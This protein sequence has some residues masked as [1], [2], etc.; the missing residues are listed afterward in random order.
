M[1]TDFSESP[2][3]ALL[4]AARLFTGREPI[5]YHAHALPMG[6]S[7]DA[8]AHSAVPVSLA[9]TEAECVAFLAATAPPEGTKLAPVIACG[10]IE[11]ML[12]RYGRD[13]GIDPVVLGSQGRSG[14]MNLLRGSTAAKLLDRIPCDTL[15]VRER[16]VAA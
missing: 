15:P 13:Y 3:H 7:A 6:V 8:S 1:A 16:R 14:A 12:T 4:A 11:T 2:R 9:E 10:A 5:L